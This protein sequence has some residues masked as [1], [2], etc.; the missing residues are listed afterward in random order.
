MF[1]P[2]NYRFQMFIVTVN[3][4]FLDT[5]HLMKRNQLSNKLQ[6]DKTV[7]CNAFFQNSPYCF[8]VL[9]LLEST[10]LQ[11]LITDV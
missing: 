9:Q 8:M 11:T 2:V 4:L 6:T 7:I 1:K 10:V 3:Y 5:F